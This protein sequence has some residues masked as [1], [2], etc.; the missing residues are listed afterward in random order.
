VFTVETPSGQLKHHGIYIE[1]AALDGLPSPDALQTDAKYDDPYGDHGEG[2]E[3]HGR[4]S[5]Q[6]FIPLP[7]SDSSPFTF[8]SLNWNPNGHPIDGV[9]TVPHFDIHFHMTPSTVVEE[10]DG[11]RA[12]E[13]EFPDRYRPEGYI[14]SPNVDER[15][16]TYMGE[17][18]ADSTA[19]ELEAGQSEFAN[20][21]IWGVYDPTDSGVAE[22]TFVEP[23]VTL[24]YLRNVTGVDSRDISQPAAY[25]RNGHYPTEYTVRDVPAGDGIAVTIDSFEYVDGDHE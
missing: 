5:Q 6:F 16:I 10:I 15:V 4:Y 2:T 25:R 7:E 8:I 19:P 14:R 9:W 24:D 22:L 20:T 17:H 1:R 21:L 3:I 23:M 13:Y 18:L 12:P 11:P